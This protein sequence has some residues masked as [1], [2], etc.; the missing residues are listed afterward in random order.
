MATA[1]VHLHAVP[2]FSGLVHLLALMV[3]A[4]MILVCWTGENVEGLFEALKYIE[5]AS[6]N[7]F[8]ITNLAICVNLSLIIMVS[9]HAWGALRT[10]SGGGLRF[11]F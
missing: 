4:S 3:E 7:M 6:A 8:A 2:L 10:S 5:M 11:L 1:T 9:N